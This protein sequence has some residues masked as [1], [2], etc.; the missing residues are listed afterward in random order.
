MNESDILTE[1]EKLKGEVKTLK[2][3]LAQYQS[4]GNASNELLNEANQQIQKLNSQV[5]TLE[6]EKGSMEKSVSE[7]S[8]KVGTLEKENAKLTAADKDFEGRVAGELRKL[9]II[10]GE[11]N[12]DNGS[13]PKPGVETSD[14]EGAE[15]GEV[16]YTQ[17]IEAAKKKQAV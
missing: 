10:S 7:L 8:D 1:N 3:Q 13:D 4:D 15:S 5:E 6:N 17:K 11:F 9:G 16:N 14:P 12:P 2:D